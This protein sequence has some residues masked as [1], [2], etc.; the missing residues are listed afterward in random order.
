MRNNRL[1]ITH[2]VLS[3]PVNIKLTDSMRCTSIS[4]AKK[5][6]SKGINILQAVF[7]DKDGK[8]YFLK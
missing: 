2:K 1:V 4:G 3:I 6:L 7:I 5:A 8:K